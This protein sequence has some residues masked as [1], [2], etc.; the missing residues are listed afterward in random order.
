MENRSEQSR[1]RKRAQTVLI[2]LAGPFLR[3]LYAF[4]FQKAEGI[5]GPFLLVANHVTAADPVLL[6]IAMKGHLLYFVASEHLM[7]K[8]LPSKLLK[9]L[10]DPIV[11]RKGDSAVTA[12]KEMLACLKAGFNVCVFPEGT[13]SYDGTNSPMLPT[14]GK[15]AKTSGCTLVTYRFEGGYFTLPR[16]GRGIRRGSYCGH[17]V[18]VYAPETLSAMSASEVN[19]AIEA[20]LSENAY[21]RIETSAVSY[22]S[23]CRA[24][25]LE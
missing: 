3:R 4:R 7:Q 9:L 15:L 2:T 20:D 11:R 16:W 21:A 14:I 22:R 10:F 19:A 23:R 24:E 6:A 13:C 1:G 18:N 8:G 25:Y 5:D 12:V 17:I